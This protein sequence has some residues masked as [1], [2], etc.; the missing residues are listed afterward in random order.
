MDPINFLKDTDYSCV[1]FTKDS[2]SHCNMAIKDL[3]KIKSDYTTCKIEECDAETLFA[4]TKCRTFPQIFV[5]REYIGGYSELAILL[6]TNRIYNML[7]LEVE[8]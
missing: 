5:K 8:F 1:V 2:C 4:H 6:M 7:D 3:K